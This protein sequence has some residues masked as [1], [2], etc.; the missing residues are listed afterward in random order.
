MYNIIKLSKGYCDKKRCKEFGNCRDCL[1]DYANQQEEWKP[2]TFE[3]TDFLESIT[4]ED[5]KSRT[6][7]K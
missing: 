5:E 4:N 2:L 7:K 3:P 1:V 6:L